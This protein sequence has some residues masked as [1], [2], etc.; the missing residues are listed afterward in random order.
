[1]T[2]Q[3]GWLANRSFPRIDERRKK[4]EGKG[5]WKKEKEKTKREGWRGGGGGEEAE[6][7]DD[8]R[9]RAK[10]TTPW[11]Y[12]DRE[13]GGGNAKKYDCPRT[14]V[15]RIRG[16]VEDLLAYNRGCALLRNAHASAN[17]RIPSVRGSH[18]TSNADVP[19]PRAIHRRVAWTDERHFP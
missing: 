16:A 19:G 9:Q 15:W 3:I 17:S 12:I 5:K 6:I 4:N 1:M 2:K 13:R 7:V 10:K 8:S 11:C 14:F 18:N